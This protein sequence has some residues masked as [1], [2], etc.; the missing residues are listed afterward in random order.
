[1]TIEEIVRQY[2][3]K[4][5]RVRAHTIGLDVEEETRKN[6][7]GMKV[8]A[9]MSEYIDPIINY[10]Y[11][12]NKKYDYKLPILL[13]TSAT[14]YFVPYVSY[15]YNAYIDNNMLNLVYIEDKT[16]D[17]CRMHIDMDCLKYATT[18]ECIKAYMSATYK[19]IHAEKLN[20]L[21]DANDKYN[22][23]KKELKDI[24]KIFAK[25]LEQK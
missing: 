3:D 24:E 11:T 23:A 6:K 20:E 9:E 7:E 5:N 10:I 22:A 16:N 13:A 12:T 4:Y 17:T 1:M 14:G 2:L 15:L 21:A 25:I 18:S 8:L 19:K